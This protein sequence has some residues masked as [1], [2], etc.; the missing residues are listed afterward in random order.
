MKKNIHKLET[1][2]D[3]DTETYTH[4]IKPF[5]INLHHS[6]AAT[7][8]LCLQLAEVKADVALIEEWIYRGQTRGLANAGGKVYSV[9]PENNATSCI[10][11]RNHINALPWL[12]FC[13]REATT[14]RIT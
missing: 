7:A 3:T 8:Y 4:A 2:T 10:Y 1:C 12:E 14:V 9:A 13:S 6:K 5:Q 11:V